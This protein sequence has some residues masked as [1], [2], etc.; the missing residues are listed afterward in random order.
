MH[1]LNSL[2]LVKFII[3]YLK[4]NNTKIPSNNNKSTILH[5]YFSLENIKNLFN[6]PKLEK[7]LTILEN[8]SKLMKQFKFYTLYNPNFL[9]NTFCIITLYNGTRYLLKNFVWTIAVK[10]NAIL[11]EVH[12]E[13]SARKYMCLYLITMELSNWL[14]QCWSVLRN[15]CFYS[16]TLVC[17]DMHRYAFS[18]SFIYLFILVLKKIM[19][20]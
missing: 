5:L 18:S 15:D 20:R 6:P 8:S 17:I 16:N 1:F 11:K 19:M 4:S 3:Y 10:L 7:I 2:T 13:T 14:L 12:L 9:F